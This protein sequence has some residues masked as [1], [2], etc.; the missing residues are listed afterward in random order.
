MF[1]FSKINDK[2]SSFFGSGKPEV[3]SVIKKA[4]DPTGG[5]VATDNPD[6]GE[7][8]EEILAAEITALLDDGTISPETEKVHR[9]A[10]SKGL[11]EEAAEDFANTVISAYFSDED[12]YEED[13]MAEKDIKE[14]EDLENEEGDE[15]DD[16][17]DEDIE[18]SAIMELSKLNEN[19]ELIL[20]GMASL[21]QT[22]QALAS[23]MEGLEAK[24]KAQEEEL[25]MMKSKFGELKTLPASQKA[26]VTHVQTPVNTQDDLSIPVVKSWVKNQFLSGNPNGISTT[27]VAALD[28]GF[29]SDRIRNNFLKERGT[30]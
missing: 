26:P 16:E 17:D 20:K 6:Q 21:T 23:K 11:S 25:T 30:K 29:I 2:I 3:D 24:N 9:W 13:D 27:E 22:L 28:N 19:N 10:V 18:K 4:E 8:N 12:D 1:E 14:I 7:S 5:P 15:E